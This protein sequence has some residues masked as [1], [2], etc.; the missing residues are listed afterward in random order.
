MISKKLDSLA[1][2]ILLASLFGMISLSTLSIFLRWGGLSLM[3]IDPLVRHL[4]LVS[5]FA[6]GVLAIGKNSHIRIDV[7][8][9][10]MERAP[11]RLRLWVDRIVT[12]AT[13]L[14]TA[15][16]LYSAWQFFLMEQEFGAEALLGWHSSTWV[17]ILPIGWG[18]LTIRWFMSFVDSWKKAETPCSMV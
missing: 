5:A 16:L 2:I 13:T 12:L 14:V 9:K 7:I 18:A 6:G 1:K 4:V 8:A 15:G 3:W 11:V 10:P 17:G